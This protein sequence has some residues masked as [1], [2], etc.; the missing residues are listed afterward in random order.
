MPQDVRDL[1][2]WQKAVDLSELVYRLTMTF[3]KDEIFGLT[4]QMRR[5]GVSV[6][7]NIAEGRGRLSPNEFRHFLGQAQG[8][9]FELKAQ[10][11]ISKRLGFGDERVLHRADC[12]AIELSKM[13]ISLI[14]KLHVA[15]KLKADG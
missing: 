11:V 1:I 8:S 7:S 9:L 4:S 10:L 12:L 6:V 5:A 15:K 3:P 2:V 13:L 14:K